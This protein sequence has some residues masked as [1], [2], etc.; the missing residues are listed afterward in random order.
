MNIIRFYPFS[1]RTTFFAPEPTPAIKNTPDWY[2]RQPASVRDDEFLPKGELSS[3]IKRCMP[4]FDAMTAGYIIPFPCDVYIDATNPAKIEFSVPLTMKQFSND[5][6]AVHAPEQYDHYPIDTNKYHKQL[7]RIMPFWAVKTPEGYSTLFMHP[8]HKDHL[9][10]L[11]IQGFIDTD[12]F[13]TDGHLSILVEKDFKGVIKQ[14]T[15]LVQVIPFKR[16][17]WKMELVPTSE[18]SAELTKQRF[19]LR[20][21]FVH[22]YKNKYRSK[23]E[24]K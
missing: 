21:N 1:E 20:S 2:K 15:P 19:K 23:K 3:T 22:S 8:L 16:E 6:F 17:D 10:F 11:A 9:P 24:F 4:I 5:M 7:F 13:I 14:G 18:S 12:K